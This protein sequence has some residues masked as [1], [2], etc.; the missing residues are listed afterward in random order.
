MGDPWDFQSMKPFLALTCWSRGL[1][2]VRVFRLWE[3]PEITLSPGCAGEFRTALGRRGFPCLNGT[4][5]SPLSVAKIYNNFDC[6][7][8]GFVRFYVFD[9]GKPITSGK[10]HKA[11]G[12]VGGIF[13]CAF[14]P[15]VI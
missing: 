11:P 3:L 6:M 7:S 9:K 14:R 2:I 13:P 5:D 10:S 8:R 1:I 15:F 12:P 4:L